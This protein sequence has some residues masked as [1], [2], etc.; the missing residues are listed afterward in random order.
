M[1]TV[2]KCTITIS[3]D[4]RDTVVLVNEFVNTAISSSF[5]DTPRVVL[6]KAV[7]KAIEQIQDNTVHKLL[8]L[9]GE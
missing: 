4:Q 1:S 7:L 8:L 9:K 2:I 3:D 6:G 5:P